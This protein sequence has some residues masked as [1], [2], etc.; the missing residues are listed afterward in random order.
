MSVNY[1]IGQGGG[2]QGGGIWPTCEVGEDLVPPE[3]FLCFF[4]ANGR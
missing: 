4:F 3:R 1:S 2:G